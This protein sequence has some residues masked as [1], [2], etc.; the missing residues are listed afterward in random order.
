MN[1]RFRVRDA[2]LYHVFNRGNRKQGIFGDASDYRS[3]VE[4]L[5]IG[6]RR[7][8]VER[9]AYCLMPNHYHLVLT[10]RTGGSIARLMSSLGTSAASRYNL[11]Y[12][13]VGH[14]FQ[15]PY[16]N[17]LVDTREGLLRL[18]K[19]IHLN[20]VEAGLVARPEDWP[21]SDFRSYLA[22]EAE[23]RPPHRLSFEEDDL[24]LTRTGLTSTAYVRYVIDTL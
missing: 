1:R 21:Y 24:L 18:S 15:G 12:R 11:K 17:N 5:E 20:P 8:G 14:L 4:M 2:E 16:K 19:Y 6:L 9:G 7:F 23:D 22:D 13:K 3:F 10:Q